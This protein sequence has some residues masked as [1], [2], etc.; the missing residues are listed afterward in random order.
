M[1]APLPPF[2]TLEGFGER[3]ERWAE[4]EQPS[5][6]LKGVVLEWIFS[7]YDTPYGGGLTRQADQPNFYW[8]QIPGTIEN[9]SVV[10]CGYWIYE[11]TRTVVCYGL[12]S[13]S[14]PL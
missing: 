7:R 8:G 1:P 6:R 13:L 11:Q 12:A 14:L 5:D 3:F 4:Q 2:W 10:T 9:G